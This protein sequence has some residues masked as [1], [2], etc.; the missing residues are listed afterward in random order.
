MAVLHAKG[1]LR[2]DEDFAHEGILGTI[3]TGCLVRGDLRS[4]DIAPWFLPQ[5][6]RLDHR[7]RRATC[8]IPNDP[9]PEGF[10]VGDIWG[11]G[12]DEPRK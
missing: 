9:F 11:A 4:D 7:V 2:L 8:W 3:F 6:R 5:R 1:Q 10:T 12:A